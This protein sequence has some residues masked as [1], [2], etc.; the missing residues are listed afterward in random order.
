MIIVNLKFE[1]YVTAAGLQASNTRYTFVTA[2]VGPAVVHSGSSRHLV[3]YGDEYYF[4]TFL[5]RHALTSPEGGWP[6]SLSTFDYGV[7]GHLRGCW[8]SGFPINVTRIIT[9]SGGRHR[10]SF[11]PGY[12]Y[13]GK[14]QCKR[15]Q[16]MLYLQKNQWRFPEW[17][18]ERAT[19][20][21]LG[22][23]IQQDGYWSK[24]PKYRPGAIFQGTSRWHHATSI[25]SVQ[26]L[27]EF[28]WCG[29]CLNP[30]NRCFHP[31]ATVPVPCVITASRASVTKAVGP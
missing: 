12:S 13:P 20:G 28:R 8:P 21:Y 7:V 18:R 2:G 27:P 29:L 4:S 14:I 10:S 26:H 31:Q 23:S 25:R 24:D 1:A 9:K 6:C 17:A 5:G 19:R 16:S 30:G 3:H 22:W 11:G 15:R